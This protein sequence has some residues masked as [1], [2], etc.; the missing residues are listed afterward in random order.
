MYRESLTRTDTIERPRE[1]VERPRP[2]QGPLT[3]SGVLALQRGAGNQAVARTLARKE[4]T[5]TPQD[6]G[7]TPGDAWRWLTWA[8]IS[9][10]DLAAEAIEAC[11]FEGYDQSA[12]FL[13]H[14]MSGGG[15]D[16][17][18]IVPDDWQEKIAAEKPKPGTYR[19]V[20]AY[21]WDI[22]D[23]KNSLGHFGLEVETIAGGV[24]LYTVTDRYYFPAF[25]D[26]KPVHHGFEVDFFGLLPAGVRQS[27]NDALALLGEW[28]HPAGMTERFEIRQMGG[29]WTF[30]LPQQWLADSGQ[31][32]NVRGSFVAG[33]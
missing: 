25:V 18:L 27:T 4:A 5:E 14:Y 26:G 15:A 32:F 9:A 31:D 24:K 22:P 11:G 12:A 16:Y 1:V 2:L 28:R 30:I 10:A 29:K 6:T 7:E 19:D 23:M 17:E 21:Q 20:S 33:K 3:P 8:G 13:K